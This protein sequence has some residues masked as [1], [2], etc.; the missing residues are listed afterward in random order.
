[1]PELGVYT[2]TLQDHQI[3]RPE[4]L[5]LGKVQRLRGLRDTALRHHVPGRVGRVRE[6]IAIDRDILL[7]LFHEKT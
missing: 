6:E 2:A 5:V 3:C 7:G 4:A 1:M